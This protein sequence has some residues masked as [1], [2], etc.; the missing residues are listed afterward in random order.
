M[1]LAPHQKA[2]VMSEPVRRADAQ[3]PLLALHAANSGERQAQ[4]DR[5][6]TRASK[7]RERRQGIKA[8]TFRRRKGDRVG[9]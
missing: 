1:L 5:V 3:R 6:L 2:G 8:C 9:G 7:Q 4:A